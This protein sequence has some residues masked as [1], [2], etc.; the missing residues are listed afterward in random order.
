MPIQTVLGTI[1][2]EELGST[3]M[4]EHTLVDT[5]GVGWTNGVRRHRGR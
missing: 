2:P 5:L 3:L 4:H 1:A